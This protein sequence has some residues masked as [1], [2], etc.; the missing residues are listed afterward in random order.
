VSVYCT[1]YC[2]HG[3]QLSD[4]K[5]IEHE[6]HVLPPKALQAEREG[7]Y[8]QAIELIQAAKPLRTHRGVKAVTSG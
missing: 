2:N 6:C 3:H 5:P 7:E 1:T 4:G 8:E